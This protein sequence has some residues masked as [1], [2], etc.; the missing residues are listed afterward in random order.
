MT[1]TFSGKTAS[2]PVPPA[3]HS[4]PLPAC[5]PGSGRRTTPAT[6]LR[7]RCP[8]R[9][10]LS[11]HIV[12]Q[13]TVAVR[14]LDEV[15]DVIGVTVASEHQL[16]P[17][18]ELL[19]LIRVVVPGSFVALGGNVVRRLRGET[20]LNVLLGLADQTV[21]YRGEAPWRTVHRV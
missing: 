15:P 18:I 14:L 20:S 8:V 6:A 16:L 9:R 13:E 21:T 1:C 10:T 17:A 5:C 12:F 3:P 7:R 19:K 2:A 11:V 4:A